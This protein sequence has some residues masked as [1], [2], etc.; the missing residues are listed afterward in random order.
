M[1]DGRDGTYGYG[2]KSNKIDYILLSP[3]LYD[4]VT[5]ARIFRKG[6]WGGKNGD[7]WPKYGTMKEKVH[8]ASDH[9]AIYADVNQ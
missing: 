4:R 3:A 8:Q 9:A 5:N 2:T 1:S 6:V 7:L